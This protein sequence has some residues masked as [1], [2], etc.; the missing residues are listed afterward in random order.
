MNEFA[1]QFF[2]MF[3]DMLAKRLAKQVLAMIE[4][5]TPRTYTRKDVCALL[6]VTSQTLTTYI[7]QGKL[8]PLKNTKG[9]G[10]LFDAQ[11]VDDM[12]CTGRLKR[13]GRIRSS[14]NYA[15]EK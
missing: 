8:I 10:D 3:A 15:K 4:E 12:I 7:Q 14:I 5:S 9:R 11:A 6:H 1:T 2:E 13:F